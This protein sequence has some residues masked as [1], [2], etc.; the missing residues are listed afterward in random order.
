LLTAF[1]KLSNQF[2]LFFKAVQGFAGFIIGIEGLSCFS[3]AA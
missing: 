2:D 1:P 3:K